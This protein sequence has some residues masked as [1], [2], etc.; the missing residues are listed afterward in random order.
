VQTDP[1]EPRTG[2]EDEAPQ[3]QAQQLAAPAAIVIPDHVLKAVLAK[4]ETGSPAAAA[5]AAMTETADDAAPVQAPNAS[6]TPAA[7]GAAA[8]QSEPAPARAPSRAASDAPAPKLRIRNDPPAPGAPSETVKPDQSAS[9]SIL[10]SSAPVQAPVETAGKLSAPALPSEDLVVQQ[11][12]SIA[13]DGAWLDRLARD[14]AGSADNGNQL[15]FRLNPENLGAL[16]VSIIRHAEGASVRL[17]TDSEVTRSILL[18]AQPSLVA[19]ARA[20]GLH[21]SDAQVELAQ[22]QP[23]S[24]NPGQ[25]QPQKQGQNHPQNQSQPQNPG[26]GQDSSRWAQGNGGQNNGQQNSQNRHSSPA[27]QPFV[28]NLGRKSDDES[29]RVNPDSNTLYA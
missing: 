10:P 28:S 7:I 21:I 15:H 4:I 5:P 27:H 20:Q 6:V 19:E 9:A 12:L 16:S 3:R 13:R 26:P 23:Q 14:I 24:Q 11:T 8:P 1:S 22:P 25:D 2:V 29:E 18:D 17:T